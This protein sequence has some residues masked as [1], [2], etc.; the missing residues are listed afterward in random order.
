MN[1]DED[2]LLNILYDRS[3]QPGKKASVMEAGMQ[4]LPDWNKDRLLAA[5]Q[6]L[7]RD[8][9]VMDPTG[10]LWHVSLTS[11][12]RKHVANQSAIAGTGNPHWHQ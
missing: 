8:G 1:S 3:Q 7:E 2:D 9:Y 6:G 11:T 12:A 5:A 10:P 4:Q